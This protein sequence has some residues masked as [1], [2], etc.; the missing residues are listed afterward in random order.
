MRA[1]K[2]LALAGLLGAA[3]SV[4]VQAA[5]VTYKLDPNHTMVLF[6][7]NHFGYSNPTADFGLGEG[8]LVFDEQHP[9][10]S[11]VEVTLP[12]ANLDTHV[13]ALDKHLKEA[14][15]FD[16][17]KYATVTFKSTKVQP[18]GARKFKVTG[19]LTVHG[20][21]RPVVLDATLNKVGPHP[22][23]KAQAIG[24]DATATLKRSDFGIGAYVPNVS[25][26]IKIRIT[27]EGAVPKADAAP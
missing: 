6:S 17:D 26:E 14:D 4:S 13:P 2:Y 12:L 21:T 10:Q 19:D 15:F 22:M 9:A 23:T 1:L 11:S 24:F 8:T 20:V 3:V 16:A 27:T 5:P 18:V 25:D 7:W